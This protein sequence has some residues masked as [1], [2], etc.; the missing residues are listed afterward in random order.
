MEAD[1]QNQIR[2]IADYER[3]SCIF[4]IALGA[5]QICLGWTAIAGIWNIIASISRWKLP[6]RIRQ[7]DPTIPEAYQGIASLVVIGIVNLVVGG[8]IGIV[9]VAFDF[10]IRDKVLT[11]AHLFSAAAAQSSAGDFSPSVAPALTATSGFDGQLRKL[12]KMKD[13]GVISEADFSAMKKKL[14]GL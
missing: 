5:I 9:F 14:L 12:A 4:W 11:H 8:F 6:D 13:D 1:E 10:Y 7:R 3:L 2:R